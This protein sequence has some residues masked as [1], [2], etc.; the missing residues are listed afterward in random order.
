MKTIAAIALLVSAAGIFHAQLALA[1]THVPVADAPAGAVTLQLAGEG[2]LRYL[3]LPIYRA[4]LWVAPQ[5]DPLDYGAHPLVLELTYDR[6]FSANAIA[7]RSLAEMR[8]IGPV[9]AEQAAR[10][11]QALQ[12]ALPDVEPGD[13]LSGRYQP[14]EGVRFELRGRS[15][16]AVPDPEFARMFF[17]IWLAPQT[18]EPGLRA[19]LLGAPP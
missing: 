10:W 3:G 8:R 9:S 1:S 14:G 16:G 6:A 13:R 4:R 2:R 18:S 11:Q 5:F 12:A 7:Q 15:T 17:G 19:Q